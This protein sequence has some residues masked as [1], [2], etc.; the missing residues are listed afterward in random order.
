MRIMLL[1]AFGLHLTYRL[2]GCSADCQVE[3][4]LP[5]DALISEVG[6][7]ATGGAAQDRPEG[8]MGGV[9]WRREVGKVRWIEPPFPETTQVTG[10]RWML[11]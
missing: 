6:G 3:H 7:D 1:S 5:S 10:L 2:V 4:L 8:G 9:K 11:S